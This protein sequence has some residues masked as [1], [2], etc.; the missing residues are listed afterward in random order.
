MEL[1]KNIKKDKIWNSG[2]LHLPLTD[3]SIMVNIDFD[4]DMAYAEACAKHAVHLQDHPEFTDCLYKKMISYCEMYRDCFDD[5]GIEIPAGIEGSGIMK[6]INLEGLI[7][8]APEGEGVAYTLY[9]DCEW[10]EEHGIEIS[11]CNNRV[12]YVGEY[13]AVNPWKE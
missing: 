3:T 2:E 12:G 1:I 11:I 8:S 13:C 7:I 10:E 5:E 9:G 4:V 6:Y